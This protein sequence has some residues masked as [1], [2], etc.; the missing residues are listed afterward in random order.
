MQACEFGPT[1]VAF[2]MDTCY[3]METVPPQ[4]ER[5]IP[6]PALRATNSKLQRVTSRYNFL[7]LFAIYLPPENGWINKGWTAEHVQRVVVAD[8]KVS[9]QYFE[10][11][12][13]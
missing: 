5:L 8:F 3:A 4:M 13:T 11:R 2:N 9:S 7:I 10:V 6:F 12:E 1:S